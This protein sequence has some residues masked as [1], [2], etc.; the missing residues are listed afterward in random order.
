MRDPGCMKD[1]ES[2]DPTGPWWSQGLLAE[3][4]GLK[5]EGVRLW[6]R[7]AAWFSCC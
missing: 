2:S 1:P 6:P 5:L 7:D 3:G 4:R